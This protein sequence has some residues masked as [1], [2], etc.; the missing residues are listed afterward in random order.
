MVPE[1][2]RNQKIQKFIKRLYNIVSD[3]AITDIVWNTNGTTIIIPDKEKFRTDTMYK[4]SKTKEYTAF[5]R[6]LHHYNFIKIKRNDDYSDEYFHKNFCRGM[7]DQLCFIRRSKE[8][9]N[10]SNELSLLKRDLLS[11]Q[12]EISENSQ[13]MFNLS[14]NISVLQMTVEKQQQKINGLIDILGEVFRMGINN[15][16]IQPQLRNNVFELNEIVNDIQKKDLTSVKSIPKLQPPKKD[17]VGKKARKE[18]SIS[19]DKKS[20]VPKNMPDFLTKSDEDSDGLY[21]DL[22]Y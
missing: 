15:E 9:N 17:P 2:L 19:K 12:N 20:P 16:K 8:K 7:E 6:S 4:I 3:P 1:I 5:L 11:I 18:K 13:N 10:F 14:D 21:K 22:F